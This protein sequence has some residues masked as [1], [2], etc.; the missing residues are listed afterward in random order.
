MFITE[1]T[2]RMVLID[3]IEKVKEFVTITNTATVDADLIYDRF[4]VNAKSIMGCF[5][6]DV[7]HPIELRIRDKGEKAEELIEKLSKFI[8]D[9][10]PPEITD[11]YAK[12]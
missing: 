8:I 4:T 5:S 10:D 7:A 2:R 11:P 9:M 3:S 1:T 6:L 12:C